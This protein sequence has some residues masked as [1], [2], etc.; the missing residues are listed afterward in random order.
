M[1]KGWRSRGGCRDPA[2]A[3]ALVLAKLKGGVLGPPSKY[4]RVTGGRDYLKSWLSCAFPPRSSPEAHPSRHLPCVDIGQYLK[5]SAEPEFSCPLHS[6]VPMRMPGSCAVPGLKALEGKAQTK[7]FQHRV[8]RALI[9][10]PFQLLFP[11]KT[12]W[13]HCSLSK[14]FCIGMSVL[15]TQPAE[16]GGKGLRLTLVLGSIFKWQVGSES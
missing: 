13:I 3:A 2:W 8:S 15:A 5:I 6:S 14:D 4:S 11:H 9:P 10:H 7:G 1:C 12:F 16:R